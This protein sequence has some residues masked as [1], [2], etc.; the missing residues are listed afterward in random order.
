MHRSN[1]SSASSTSSGEYSS[2]YGL[3]E[4]AINPPSSLSESDSDEHSSQLSES[5]EQPTSSSSEDGTDSDDEPD[6]REGLLRKA[7][8]AVAASELDSRGNPKYSLRA[9]AKDFGIPRSTLTGRWHGAKSKKEAHVHQ[10]HFTPEEESI[11]IDWIRT[12]GHRGVPMTLSSLRDFASG[13]L[14]KPVGENW[15]SR[16]VKRHPEIKVQFQV[17]LMIKLTMYTPQIKLTT[18]LEACR[19]RSL[20]H[21]NV[22]KYFDILEEVIAKYNIRPDNIWNMDEKGLVLG[23]SDRSKALVD[24]DQKTLYDIGDGSREMVTAIECFSAAG[25]G[26]RPMLIFPGAR[27]NLE[28]GRENPSNA[29]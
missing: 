23:A 9:A 4:S 26:I 29:M 16:F 27:I 12:L 20:N 19:A 5:S 1:S 17:Q 10:M 25:S 15:A 22:N 28:W 24:R 2:F 11:L 6:S 14:G 13:A 18:T 21:A 7:L 3:P 8:A